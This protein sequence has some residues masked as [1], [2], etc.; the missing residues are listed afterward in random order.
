MGAFS[1]CVV[2]WLALSTALSFLAI[3]G[4]MELRE[5]VGRDEDVI[6]VEA[7]VGPYLYDVATD[8]LVPAMPLYVDDM[9]DQ[10]LFIGFIQS[11]RDGSST[12]L[13]GDGRE[14]YQVTYVT[15]G[16]LEEDSS[17]TV[18]DWGGNFT[19]KQWAEAGGD[20]YPEQPIAVEDLASYDAAQRAERLDV[21]DEL[22]QGVVGE[23][24]LTSN[25]AY[26]V[27]QDDYAYETLLGT[28]LRFAAGA[29]PF[30]I[31]ITLAIV[32]F[33]RFYRLR[34]AAPLA[35][36]H[37]AADS[38]ARQDLDFSVGEVRG[39]EFARLGEAFEQMRESL[40][41][42]QQELWHTA[43]ERRRLNAAFAHDLRTPLTVLSGTVEMAR[44]RLAGMTGPADAARGREVLGNMAEQVERI[45]RY[46]EVMSQA[47]KLE[48]RPVRRELT[49]MG[50]LV[51]GMAVEG[52]A[53]V[54]ARCE[55]VTLTVTASDQSCGRT[56]R[57]RH[58]VD[59]DDATS[60]RALDHVVLDV[61]T[62]LAWEV[63][64]NLLSNACRYAVSAVT[65]DIAF[66]GSRLLFE[67]SDD[68][69]GFSQEALSRGC[70]PFFGENRSEEHFGMG[71]SIVAVLARLHGGDVELANAKPPCHG[72]CVR[73]HLD[74]T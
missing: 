33:R 47:N 1:C 55:G 45:E 22:P 53:L 9:S 36:L 12:T 35:T 59:F 63:L 20:P 11:S 70:E 51:R 38:I 54:A 8:E 60:T 6:A 23:G 56:G 50:D 66:D 52:D 58:I 68:G 4:L 42:A 27:G 18:Y 10:A 24:A 5:A 32:F 26:Y 34:L 74:V 17:F 14:D 13:P 37:E 3:V 69:P 49:S 28:G 71:L 21:R 62:E 72:A 40:V 48:D 41:D 2:A 43:E 73:V 39:S 65:V 25:V 46:V 61:D 19:E 31:F 44:M 64:G 15:K 16:M 67:V 57:G 7:D 30:I 29:S